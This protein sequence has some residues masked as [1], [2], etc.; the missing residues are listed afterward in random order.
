M[1]VRLGPAKAHDIVR[2]RLGRLA[3]RWRLSSADVHRLA[4]QMQTSTYAPGQVVVPRGARADVFGLVVR[5]Q[6]AVYD[7]EGEGE[8]PRLVLLPGSTF[9]E[10]M[11]AE[12]RPS[13]D[14]LRARTATEIRYLRRADLLALRDKPRR[15]A[16]S[17][18]LG[19]LL[20]VGAGLLLL[21]ALLILL[22][23]PGARQALAVAPMSLGQWCWDQGHATCTA[24]AWQ[25]ASSL[26][27]GEPGPLLALGTYYFQQ[28]N[29]A[30][31]ERAF[32][33]AGELA[34]DLP[35]VYN[36]L[37][38]IYARRGQYDRAIDDF[39]QALELEPGVASVE[40]N[41]AYSLQAQGRYEEALEHYAAALALDE[42]RAGTLLNMAIAYYEAG[43]PEQAAAAAQQALSQG[44]DRPAVY[45]LLAAV[46]LAQGQPERALAHL[47]QAL[48][49]N[50]G[51]E[52]AH[53]YQGLAYKALDQR[54]AA[55][56][57]FE[58]ALDHGEDEETRAR[59]REY[60]DEL[61]DTQG[62]RGE[63]G[64]D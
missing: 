24:A 51:D 2:H 11:L 10:M 46:D 43:Q 34:P 62:T 25:A 15:V 60:L 64:P 33:Q 26:T 1:D 40:D 54:E 36:N 13:R 58:Q 48:Y 35:E 18:P 27:P 63:G 37:G 8:R 55:I 57:A 7:G 4:Q 56:E 28:G 52:Q 20:R 16:R 38:L 5:G 53:F 12:G 41:L 44:G 6:V 45:G 49:L 47:E 42:P 3:R 21:L 29:T 22:A 9:G 17:A 23:R 61:N 32:R 14:T 50:P 59:I 31:A 39:E 19:G 30:A